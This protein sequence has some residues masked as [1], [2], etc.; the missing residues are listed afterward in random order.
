MNDSSPFCPNC[1]APQIRVTLP[2]RNWEVPL[3]SEPGAP[4]TVQPVQRDPGDKKTT[5]TRRQ[6]AVRAALNAGVLAAVLGMVPLPG[7]FLIALPLAGV[8]SVR[9]FRRRTQ[10]RLISVGTGFRL[11]ALT[12]L[13]GAIIS[14]LITVVGTLI[15]HAEN[16]LRDAIVK[17]IHQAQARAVDAQAR[18]ALNYFLSPPGMLVMV[19]LGAILVTAVFVVLGGLGGALSASA[20]GRS[21]LE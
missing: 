16:Q 9:L 1:G 10:L 14:L 15:F 4:S 13:F 11:G 17:S 12:G 7:A 20:S 21:R 18:E 3:H 19:I 6:S 2:E 5:D 8:I